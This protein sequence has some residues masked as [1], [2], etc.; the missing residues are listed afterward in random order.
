MIRLHKYRRM[1]DEIRTNVEYYGAEMEHEW[2]NYYDDQ[3]D[4]IRGVCGKNLVDDEE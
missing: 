1:I 3:L 2:D 4:Y